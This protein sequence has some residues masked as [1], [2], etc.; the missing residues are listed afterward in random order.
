M[1]TV[2]IP[3]VCLLMLS[4][5][6]NDG[7]QPD[8]APTD[9]GTYPDG[10]GVNPDPSEGCPDTQPKVGENC[11]PGITES[12]RCDFTV[13]ECTSANGTT[14]VETAS[15]CCPTGT[16]E[17]CGGRSP[18]DDM[19]P[20]VDAAEPPPPTPDAGV[21]D[22]LDALGDVSPEVHPDAGID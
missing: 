3:L 17:N 8:R 13:G 4:V 2:F 7:V 12:N 10:G 5:S 6:C 19:P 1:R 18:C 9:P 11:S 16:W 21:S 22:A 15:F 20:E 14:Y